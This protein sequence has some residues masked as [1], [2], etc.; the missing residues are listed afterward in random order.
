[1]KLSSFQLEELELIKELYK[2]RNERYIPVLLTLTNVEEETVRD[3]K[4]SGAKV[5]YVFKELSIVDASLPINK[6]RKILEKGY[7][8]NYS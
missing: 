5:E 7:V 8:E 2:A 4:N 3:L 6:L 1:M